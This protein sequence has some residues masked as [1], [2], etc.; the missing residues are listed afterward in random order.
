MPAKQRP[1]SNAYGPYQG[2]LV[3]AALA[4][5]AFAQPLYHLLGQNPAFLTAHY[6]EPIDVVLIVLAVSIAAPL[7]LIAIGLAAFLLGRLAWLAVHAVTVIVLVAAIA[8]QAIAAKTLTGTFA[9]TD[10]V[11][12]AA[13]L[14]LGLLALLLLLRYRWL[15]SAVS[16]ASIGVLVFPV[17]FLANPAINAFLYPPE[18]PSHLPPVS[19]TAPVVVLVLD[20]LP[21]TSLLNRQRQIDAARFPNFARLADNAYWFSNATTVS[22]DTVSGAVPAIVTGI[23]PEEPKHYRESPRSLFTLLGGSYDLNVFETYTRVCPARLCPKREITHARIRLLFS[24]LKVVMAHLLF[25]PEKRKSLP[26]IS[27]GWKN[28]SEQH[29]SRSELR[30]KNINKLW[31]SR[32]GWMEEFIGSFKQSEK[33]QLYFLHVLLPHLPWVFLPNGN[34]YQLEAKG[35]YGVPGV[36]KE[37]WGDNTWAV[38][39]GQQRHVLQL[40]Y[41][42]TLLGKML[43]RLETLG[44][45]EEALIVVTADHGVSFR[46]NDARRPLTNTNA[47]DIMRIPLLIKAPRQKQ[48]QTI[49][50]PVESVDIL[51]TIADILNLPLAWKLDG[52]SALGEKVSKRS[53]RRVYQQNRRPEGVAN[54][55]PLAGFDSLDDGLAQ[56]LALLGEGGP[57]TTLYSLGPHKQLVGQKLSGYPIA[58][59][60]QGAPQVTLAPYSTGNGAPWA[61]TGLLHGDASTLAV[62]DLAIA[63][64]G[65]ICSVTR[66]YRNSATEAAFV[67]FVGPQCNL[68]NAKKLQVLEITRSKGSIVFSRFHRHDS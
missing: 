40:G 13:G 4:A 68:D 35:L 1:T 22:D 62:A 10:T 25:P 38:E 21:T 19:A 26:D 28:F 30:A 18:N 14:A 16:L 66:T 17:V 51:P 31:D 41:V 20:E 33:P 9:L 32:V 3:T 6:A 48:G 8:V 5:F 47:A 24:D 2:I 58:P 55:L 64:D 42:D 56:K 34:Q 27:Q 57:E 45:Y 65:A 46:V 53:M 50:A 52:Y 59:A 54:H 23:Y 43:D 61:I 15:Q 49:T 12:I 63:A 60:R 36:T 37:H 29:M 67:A 44:L 11:V 7:L 39:Q